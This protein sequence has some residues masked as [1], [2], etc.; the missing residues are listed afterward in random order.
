[1]C[2][3]REATS[4]V[5]VTLPAVRSIMRWSTFFFLVLVFVLLTYIAYLT[6]TRNLEYKIGGDIWVAPG[7]AGD[8]SI[9]FAARL[10]EA[11]AAAR[12]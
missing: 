6:V 1:M 7:D 3:R 8:I 11:A 4:P 12:A 2:Y 5:R 10:F 9:K